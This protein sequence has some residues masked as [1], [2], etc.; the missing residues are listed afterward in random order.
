M[1]QT[2]ICTVAKRNGCN[3]T[4]PGEMGA[5]G[6]CGFE[7]TEMLRRKA[8]I[9]RDGLTRDR[10]TGKYYLKIRKEKNDA[11]HDNG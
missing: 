5:C 8:A 1:E 2:I 4:S 7:Q 9:R 6:H 10:E 3:C 11:G